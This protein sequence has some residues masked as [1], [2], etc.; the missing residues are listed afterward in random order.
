[1]TLNAAAGFNY[2]SFRGRLSR[3]L[4]LKPGNYIVTITAVDRARAQSNAPTLSFTLRP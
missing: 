1:V 2:V 4:S 3:S